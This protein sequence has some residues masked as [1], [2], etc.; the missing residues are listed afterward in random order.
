M[1]PKQFHLLYS[2]HREKLLHREMVAALTT[3]AVINYSLS[4]PET[5]VQPKDFMPNYTASATQEPKDEAVPD[6]EMASYNAKR[7][8]LKALLQKYKNTG[9][10]DPYLI[11]LGLVAPR[12]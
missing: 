3:A 10:A 4:R 7:A 8:H 11:E 2:R 6:A 9:K 12:A 5:P 1:T